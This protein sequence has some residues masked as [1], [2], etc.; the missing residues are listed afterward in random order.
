MYLLSL[1]DDSLTQ[2]LY[3]FTPQGLWAL[4]IGLAH[5]TSYDIN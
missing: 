5:Q 4:V 3:A 1:I 2:N